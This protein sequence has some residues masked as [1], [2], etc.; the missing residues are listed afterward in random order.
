MARNTWKHIVRIGARV[1][2]AAAG[3]IVGGIA[4]GGAFSPVGA[5]GGGVVGE[6]LLGTVADAALKDQPNMG[7]TARYKNSVDQFSQGGKDSSRLLDPVL[8]NTGEGFNSAMQGVD[9]VVG[10][11]GQGTS[12]FGGK[13]G[14][15]TKSNVNT[16][17]NLETPTLGDAS[18]YGKIGMNKTAFSTGQKSF[19]MG[20]TKS[21]APSLYK[22]PS[23]FNMKSSTSLLNGVGS[24]VNLASNNQYK[25][26]QTKIK[27]INSISD[28]IDTQMSSE[29]LK[30]NNLI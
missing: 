21:M 4:G 7:Y 11:I 25:G 27:A 20:S 30:Y 19:D 5:I 1:V 26:L 23:G 28:P 10:L 18:S 16:G 14:G 22:N 13:G 6:E 29:M 3:A 9:Q 17:M 2:G 12:L 24:F 15:G 8:K